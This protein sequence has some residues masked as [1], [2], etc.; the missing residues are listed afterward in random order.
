[1]PVVLVFALAAGISVLIYLFSQY[2]LSK[3]D[4]QAAVRLQTR[5]TASSG[6]WH[7]LAVLNTQSA[8][9]EE[10]PGMSEEDEEGFGFSQGLFRDEEGG[11]EEEM[12]DTG[13]V[14]AVDQPLEVVPFLRTG[15]G[16]AV[17]HLS[18]SGLMRRLS[19][20]AVYRNREKET[21][22]L[23]GSRPFTRPDTVLYLRKPERPKGAGLVDGAVG[24]V[25]V[26]VDSLAGDR[27]HRLRVCA[28]ELKEYIDEHSTLLAQTLDTAF[29]SSPLRVSHTDDLA[30][31]PDMVEGTLVLDATFHTIHW[32]QERTIHVLRHLQIDGD[33]RIEGLKFVVGGEIRLNVE[34]NFSAADEIR[35]REVTLFSR[36]RIFFAR[37]VV[38]EGS[39]LAL[40]DV[41]IY[42]NAQIV[43]K[44]VIASD[45]APRMKAETKRAAG[46]DSAD[47]AVPK[48]LFTIY[49]RNEATV[50]G[51][52]LNL[53]QKG[54]IKTGPETVLRGVLWA[55]GRVCHQG[56]LEGVIKA[57]ALVAADN[58]MDI[59]GNA[60]DGSVRRLD[61]IGD[62]HLPYFVG[63]LTILEWTE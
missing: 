18:A 35:M 9:S 25:P 40:G 19:S 39:A 46:G 62:Y 49:V 63:E 50:D 53:N 30:T 36:S 42:H 10:E 3:P 59:Q 44:S 24:L 47:V 7:G 31:V 32:A 33:A 56:E 21:S 58:P 12:E 14:L 45:A 48:S 16:T 20:R 34:D 13:L 55:E 15:F 11:W 2:S 5:L 27:R 17:L 28:P 54:G 52:L 1:M 57:T 6:I 22:V 29:E 8:K 23:L 37:N 51:V 4:L 43:N 61:A 26:E 60:M 41:E 38:F